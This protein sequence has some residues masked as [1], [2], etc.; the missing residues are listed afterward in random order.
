MND[1][2]WDL[3]TPFWID[4]DGYTDRDREMFCAG[5]EFQMIC[6]LLDDGWE[7]TRPMRRENESRVRM[8]CA[9]RGVV[10]Q[11]EQHGGCE[12]WSQLTVGVKPHEGGDVK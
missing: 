10:C 6:R 2:S 3:V 8:L 9:K 11:I 4:T 5:V 7:G 12:T 1:E